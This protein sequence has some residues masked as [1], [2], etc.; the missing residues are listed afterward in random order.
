MVRIAGMKKSSQCNVLVGIVLAAGF[1]LSC[2]SAATG[3]VPAPQCRVHTALEGPC[4]VFDDTLRLND[5]Q[6]VGTHNSYK[7]A[8][9][10]DEL[11]II[12]Q[13][14]KTAALELDYAHEPLPLQLDMGG[15][16][17]ELDVVYDPAGGRYAHPL[18]PAMTA[19]KPGSVPYDA[20]EM[21]LPGFKVLHVTDVDMRSQCARFVVCLNQIKNWSDA[22]SGHVPILI[23][24]NA[25]D[26]DDI[27][28]GGVSQLPFDAAAFDALDA[29]I[30]SVFSAGDLITPDQVRG[31]A[32]TL[33]DAVRRNGWPSLDAARGKFLFALDE[34]P[35][36]VRIYMRGH[37]SLEGLPMFVNSIGE[38]APHA[39]YFTLNYPVR[40]FA[41]IR[42]AIRA[43]FIVRTRADEGTHEAR[44]TDVK[45][46][47]AAFASGAQYVSTD[48]PKPRPEF[49]P[50]AVQ[51]PESPPARCN[52]VRRDTICKIVT[53]DRK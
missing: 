21:G 14:S 49:G 41:R 17:I 52:P 48:Y 53:R 31:T 50:Y 28:P 40:D 29:E 39:A 3:D 5:L 4:R 6:V 18:L 20:S 43:G 19:G 27:V 9:P 13:Q 34:G 11:A 22:H 15:R 23:T 38:N 44:E 30:R 16:T 7:S 26:D 36:K 10:P 42:A 35:K 47:E 45:R 8:I 51:L 25:K 33:R 46:R 37:A 24:I 2:A 1:S 32:A 12:R